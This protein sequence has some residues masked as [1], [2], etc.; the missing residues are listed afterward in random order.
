[1]PTMDG[2]QLMRTLRQQKGLERIPAVAL[3]GYASEKDAQMAI[4]AG[5]NLHL[6]KPID[7]A[8]LAAVVESLLK[9]NS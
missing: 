2:L 7:P 4:A 3:T 9:Q 6:A 5:F 1:M 8:E